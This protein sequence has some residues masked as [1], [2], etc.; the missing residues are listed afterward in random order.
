[1]K[2]FI[3]ASP[4]RTRITSHDSYGHLI[5]VSAT[6][7]VNLLLPGNRGH[8]PLLQGALPLVQGPLPLIE[9]LE[10]VQQRPLPLGKLSGLP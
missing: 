6:L 9:R 8:I 3:S 1:M 5:L 7:G 10:P 4:I 2:T